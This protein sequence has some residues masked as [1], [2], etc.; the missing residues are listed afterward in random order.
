MKNKTIL[1]NM[2]VFVAILIF[3]NLV[4]LSV[5]TRIDLSKG[6]VYSLSKASKNTVRELDDRLV[7]K[8]YF[9]KNLPGEYADARRYTQDMLSEYQAY[10]RGRLRFEFI[11]PANEETL[12][13][14][15]QKNQIS[16]V[17]MRVVENDKLEIREVYMGL[18]FLYQD[19]IESI[20][21]IQNT[22]GLEYD[23]TSTIKRISA[24]GL[25]K[26]AFFAPDEGQ[27]IPQNPNMPGNEQFGTVRQMLM[28]SYELNEVDL[29]MEIDPGT[30]VLFFCGIKDSLSTEQL[31]NLDQYIMKG[32]NV[33]F[34]QD[35]VDTDIQTQS[36][37]LIN[38]NIFDLFRH[39]GI[40]IKNNLVADAQCGQ[41][42]IQRMQGIFRI[43]T[44]VNYPFFPIVSNVNSENLIVKNLDQIQMIF[45]SEI[46]TTRTREDLD[47]E[48]LF[49]ST[50]YSGEALAPRFNINVNQ[51]MNQDLKKMF[52]DG[53]KVLAGIYTGTFRSFFG[54]QETYPEAVQ[55]TSSASIL[56]VPDREFIEDAGAAGIKGNLDFVLNATDYMASESTLIEIRSRET[57]FKPLKEL[58][59]PVRKTVKWLN[60]LLPAILMIV[61]G[62]LRY[63]SELK[64]RKIIGDLYE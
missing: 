13:Q 37:S 28:E 33:I 22:R 41:V 21:L 24:Q 35:R 4:S 58:S 55:E 8:A 64:K 48:P 23:I 47:F 16:P 3:L 62:I 51:Y 57:E 36:A 49:Y 56:L 9:S 18:A 34:F 11:D 42:Q 2:I 30:S 59:N 32:G 20:P 29:S 31:Y 25:K 45:A 19:K 38:S 6:K 14:E 46:D 7:I 63:R 17:S 53:P 15:A 61:F 40:R 43:A 52:L 50:Q 26:L 54:D 10:S 39:Y 60:I 5:F 1:F 44:P 27:V 12:K